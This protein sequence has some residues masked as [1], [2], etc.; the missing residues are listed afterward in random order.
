MC[1][2]PTQMIVLFLIQLN[3]MAVSIDRNDSV[4]YLLTTEKLIQAKNEWRRFSQASC[5]DA[6]INAC[7]DNR[8]HD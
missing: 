4:F 6:K 3:N 8:N 7:F 1:A 5:I 2:G